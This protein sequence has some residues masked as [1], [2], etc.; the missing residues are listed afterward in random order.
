[1][2]NLLKINIKYNYSEPLIKVNEFNIYF[3]LKFK[4]KQQYKKRLRTSVVIGK[5]KNSRNE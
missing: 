2:F 1:M 4:S 5:S 3:N